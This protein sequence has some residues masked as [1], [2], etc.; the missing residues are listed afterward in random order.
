MGAVRLINCSSEQNK[1]M[2]V[3]RVDG[4]GCQGCVSRVKSALESVPKV[5]SAKV[6]LE[7]KL[8]W[9]KGTASPADLEAAVKLLGKEL[10]FLGSAAAE[11]FV[12]TT[13]SEVKLVK[14]A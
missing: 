13:A 12:E 14:D 1:G 5:K 2:L 6:D 8:V 7:S 4:M 3:F 10:T 9:V 11:A